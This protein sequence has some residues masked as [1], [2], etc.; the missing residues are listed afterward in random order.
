METLSPGAARRI[1]LAAQ[2][3]GARTAAS[4]RRAVA[5]VV[6]RVGL[7]QIDSVNVLVRSH[8]LPVFSRQG[9]YDM[10]A[11]DAAAYGRR[12]SLFEYWGHEASLIPLSTYPLLRWRMERAARAE[13][14]YSGLARFAR[15]R[16]PFIDEVLR[17][18]ADR[19]PLS[20]GELSGGHKGKGSWWGWSDGKR[21]LEFLFWSGRVTTQS[22]RGF[23]RV[24]DLTERVLPRELVEV[25]APS[26]HEAHRA[27]LSIAARAYG[28]A[29]ERDLRDYW[30][31]GVEETRAA[32]A[33]LVE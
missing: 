7:I 3:F 21:A 12:R 4:D 26:A 33:E 25:P 1:A 14:I 32:L 31:L 15:E 11:L 30:R 13:S 23:E 17:E 9:G 18:V 20:A 5:A 10:A 19:G 6:D 24:Y 22:R 16:R 8:Y 28:V 29:T 2:G 27:L